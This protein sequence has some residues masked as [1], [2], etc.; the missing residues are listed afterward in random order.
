MLVS[1]LYKMMGIERRVLNMN[2]TMTAKELGGLLSILGKRKVY[3]TNAEEKKF[4][5]FK[6][7]YSV[8]FNDDTVIL[9]TRDATKVY[10]SQYQ[11]LT[12]MN[13][14]KGE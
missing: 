5:S 14:K 2:D 9:Y 6:K 4:F 11:N 10:P 12:I 7:D 13:S 8:T 1:R 3:F